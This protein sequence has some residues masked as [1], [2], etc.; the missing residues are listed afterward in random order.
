MDNLVIDQ[1]TVEEFDIIVRD[2]FGNTIDLTDQ[3]LFMTVKKS[4]AD[5]DADAVFKLDSNGNGIMINPAQSVAVNR[6]QATIKIVPS[7]TSA[8]SATVWHLVYDIRRKTASGDPVL[9]FKGQ[10]TIS[11]AITKST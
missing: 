9:V 10:V 11:P 1:G 3:T 8:L 4:F 5:T 2:S 6:G 7:N